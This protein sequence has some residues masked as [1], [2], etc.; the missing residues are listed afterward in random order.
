MCR[1]KQT[2]VPLLSTCLLF[3]FFGVSAVFPAGVMA[4]E[5]ASITFYDGNDDDPN[6]GPSVCIL[7]I[8]SGIYDF[9]DIAECV[10]D[11]ARFFRV[12][13]APSATYIRLDDHPSCDEDH[14]DDPENGH[15]Q[16]F[17]FIFKVVK[18]HATME[19]PISFS[20]LSGT[21]EG[22]I[23]QGAP[24]LRMEFNYIDKDNNQING[25][26]SCVKITRSAVPE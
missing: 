5:T 10:N 2:F 7:P 21:A 4:E 16:N 20:Q 26:L 12:V 13:N 1:F 18:N 9:K 8:E 22:Q 3:M 25:K 15:N 19:Q 6:P 11:E 14:D 23:I 17:I 24:G